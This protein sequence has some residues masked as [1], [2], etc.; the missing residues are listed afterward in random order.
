MRI[1]LQKMAWS[2]LTVAIVLVLNFFLFRV[3]PGDP[4]RAG[5]KDPR[6]SPEAQAA[7]RVRFGLDH[8]VINGIA[9]LHPLRFGSWTTNPLQT[10]FFMYFRSLAHLDLGISYHS[11]RPV[12]EI[13]RERLGNT[14]LLVGAGQAVAIV[15]GL[16]LGALSAWKAGKLLDR[17]AFVLGLIGWS[18][19]TF[20]L[21]IMLLFYG[22]THFYLPVGGI[23]TPGLSRADIWTQGLDIGRHLLLPTIAQAIV[24]LAQYLLIARSAMH[25]TLSEDYILTARAKGLSPV[26]ILIHHAAQNASLPVMTMVAMNLGFVV[27]GAIQIETVFS[28]PGL[29]LATFE[30]VMRRDYPL[31]QG[32]FLLLAVSVVVANMVADL[33]YTYLDPRV[34]H[35]S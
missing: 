15:F 6:M 33:L 5:V 26:H 24:Y 17:S 8:P 35:R 29:G 12:S 14:L 28:W 1:V 18:L 9:S 25:D 32:T 20:W 11:G 4:A 31:L 27:A 7:I 34:R 10:Q 30:A 3:L 23:L 13:L 16:S 22:S 19:P 21:G 2:L